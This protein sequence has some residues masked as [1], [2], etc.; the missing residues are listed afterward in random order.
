[1]LGKVAAQLNLTEL[2]MYLLQ[3]RMLK[4]GGHEKFHSGLHWK[5]WETRQ[6]E[7]EPE[8]LHTAS[9][10][11]RYKSKCLNSI[12]KEQQTLRNINNMTVSREILGATERYSLHRAHGHATSQFKWELLTKPF[13]INGSQPSSPG[14]FLRNRGP[15]RWKYWVLVVWIMTQT[16]SA[17]TTFLLSGKGVFTLYHCILDIGKLFLILPVI[18]V[19]ILLWVK[20]VHWTWTSLWGSSG[21]AKSMELL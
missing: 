15:G 3:G 16:F 12:N 17:T 13:Q 11:P 2:T 18:V 9:E 7:A 20:R 1:M 10:K 5:V 6:S 8:S 14:D 21:T 19:K 4:L